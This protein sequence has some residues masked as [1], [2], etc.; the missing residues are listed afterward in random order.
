MK[1]IH[2]LMQNWVLSGA[3]IVV[4]VLLMIEEFKTQQRNMSVN[5]LVALLNS[6]ECTLLDIRD[7]NVFAQGHI[8]Q[9]INIPAAKLKQDIK[10][11]ALKAKVV[12][13][14]K[15]PLAEQSAARLLEKMGH[16]E[17]QF[18]HGGMGAWEKANMP[19]VRGNSNKQGK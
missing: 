5:E 9:A 13:V 4:F 7:A 2:F 15:S 11:A 8:A 14:G 10:L 19:L 17:C 18:L 16:A 3:F 6:G 12:I 1:F